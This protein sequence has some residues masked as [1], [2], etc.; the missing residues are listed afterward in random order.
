MFALIP[1]THD[2]TCALCQRWFDFFFFQAKVNFSYI[3]TVGTSTFTPLNRQ[4]STQT[5][6][7]YDRVEKREL[8]FIINDYYCSLICLEVRF[9][10]VSHHSFHGYMLSLNWKR[11]L[12]SSHFFPETEARD[13]PWEQGLR[14]DGVGSLAISLTLCLWLLGLPNTSVWTSVL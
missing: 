13:S 14:Q 8:I 11:A 2:R 3:R 7:P 5:L 1:F 6:T 12:V 4:F 10:S 9:S